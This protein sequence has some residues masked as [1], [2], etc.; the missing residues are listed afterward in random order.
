MYLFE[1][2]RVSEHELGEAQREREEQTGAGLG[3]HPRARGH[4]LSRRRSLSPLSP[5]LACTGP[6][7]FLVLGRM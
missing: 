3:L 6:R 2:E 1:R 4:D 5:L 7:M